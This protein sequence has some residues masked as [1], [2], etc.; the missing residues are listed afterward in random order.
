MGKKAEVCRIEN[1]ES[2]CLVGDA[3]P[4]AVHSHQCRTVLINNALSLGCSC[5]PL[6]QDVNTT[7]YACKVLVGTLHITSSSIGS[8]NYSV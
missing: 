7:G 6:R 8:I 2:T 4:H 3:S 5:G 1:W